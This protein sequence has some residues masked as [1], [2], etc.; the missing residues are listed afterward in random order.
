MF[1]NHRIQQVLVGLAALGVST[2][3][4]AV[5]PTMAAAQSV[6]V[7]NQDGSGDFTILQ[8]AVD[9]ATS[10]DI[11]LVGSAASGPTIVD[12]K[13][14]TLVGDGVHPGIGAVVVRNVPAGA[15]LTLR[16]LQL[17]GNNGKAA[18]DLMDNAGTIFLEQ[19]DLFGA[20]GIISIWP[21][22]GAG[23]RASHCASVVLNA[24][25]LSGGDGTFL[26]KGAPT[27][28]A[29]GLASASSQFSA[30]R[31]TFGGGRGVGCG[32][33]CGMPGGAG[34]QWADGNLFLSGATVVGGE[35]AGC[36]LCTGADG[37][38][39]TSG[40]VQFVESTFEAA[41]VSDF[42]PGS[43][44]DAPPGS[45]QDLMDESR[46]VLVDSPLRSFEL[47]ELNY[48]GGPLDAVAVF[49]AL[50]TVPVAAPVKKG[51]WSLAEPHFGPIALGTADA[52]GYLLL[53]F[54]APDITPLQGMVLFVQ[55]V[56]QEAGSG[57]LRVGGPS[58][59]VVVDDMF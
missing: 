43:D 36:S 59:L 29:A 12:G 53:A 13:A 10:G 6:I 55:P 58:T 25:E 4:G 18:L 34:I 57:R 45:V 24:S 26:F 50:G 46:V 19:L 37:L 44:I 56:A 16:N 47:G 11:I 54:E 42:L 33:T 7:F 27:A 49:L 28:G 2:F 31:T 48:A 32:D 40:A 5:L 20:N 52:Q 22:P 17:S 23:L 3:A 51:V 15:T 41:P 8:E 9:A 30:T 21:F 14:L 39:V 38:H 35:S 1:K